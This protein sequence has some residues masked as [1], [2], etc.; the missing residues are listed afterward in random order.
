MELQDR[1]N[2]QGCR[3]IAGRKE[4][5]DHCRIEKNYRMDAQE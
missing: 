4:L 2:G 1:H 3:L 5:Q